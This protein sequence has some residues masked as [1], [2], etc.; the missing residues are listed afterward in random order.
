MT[1]ISQMT[2]SIER[3][4]AP[5]ALRLLPP[6]PAIANRILALASQESVGAQ[7]VGALIRLDPSFSAEVL[8]FANSA[9]FGARCK[10]TSLTQAVALLGMNRVKSMATFVAVNNLVRSAVRAAAL[11]KV[12]VHS[13]VTAI[14]AEAAA[15][16]CRLDSEF[17]YTAGLLHNLG[18]LGLMSAYP[19]EYTRMLEV[20]DD[21]G[22]NLLHTERDLFDIDHCEAGAFLAREWN[23]PETLA[24][25]IARH[26]EEPAANDLSIGN[27][28]KLSWRLTDALGYAAFSPAKDWLFEDLLAYLPQAPD[29]WLCQSAEIAR[30]T[31]RVRLAASPL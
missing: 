2:T 31:I 20:S 13:V 27:I 9:L 15:N 23:F 14:I 12:W 7:E 4:E 29:S 18:I 21:F 19:E 8:S 1:G 5:W 24:V 3:R 11:R 10:V 28:I 26:H 6:F 30:E 25:T 22:F 17:A 16:N